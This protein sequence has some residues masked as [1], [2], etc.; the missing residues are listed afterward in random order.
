MYLLDQN[1]ER[2]KQKGYHRVLRPVVY[3]EVE[4]TRRFLRASRRM[5]H[6]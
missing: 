3:Y 2:D 5:V 1:M 4:T 6:S